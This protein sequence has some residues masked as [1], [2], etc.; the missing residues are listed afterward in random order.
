MNVSYLGL[1]AI[2]REGKFLGSLKVKT[3][4]FLK[5]FE[6]AL[7]LKVLP[8]IITQEQGLWAIGFNPYD[9]G[10][11]GLEGRQKNIVSMEGF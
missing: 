2:K 5:K 7:T 6:P 9:R 11:E 10:D 1:V 3:M 8:W 4:K